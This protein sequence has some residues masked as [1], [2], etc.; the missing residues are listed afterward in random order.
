MQIWMVW[1]KL[2]PSNRS[3][4]KRTAETSPNSMRGIR[5]SRRRSTEDHLIK[6]VGYARRL[7]QLRNG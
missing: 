2:R 4:Y 3:G 5:E 1:G 7:A 6:R